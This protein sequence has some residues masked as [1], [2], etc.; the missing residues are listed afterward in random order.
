MIE[1]LVSQGALLG[2]FACLTVSGGIVL[3]IR[4]G[5]LRAR[6]R[7]A[8]NRNRE[9]GHILNNTSDGIVFLS[10]SG[11][12]IWANE[13][14]LAM[15]GFTLGEILGRNPL[16]YAIP[17][18]DR[19]PQQV[20]DS[21]RF[22]PLDPQWTELHVYRN[23]R[24][25]GSL[26][27]N[28]ISLSFH[29]PATGPDLTILVCRDISRQI[30]AQEELAAARADLD[31]AATR[32]SLTGLANR[33]L[34]MDFL[35]RL[36]RRIASGERVG[37][38]VVHIDVDRFKQINDT[39]GHAAGDAVLC[40]VADVLAARCDGSSLMSRPGGDE[41]VGVISGLA[42]IESLRDLAE[43]LRHDIGTGIG[44]Q[45][46][47]ISTSVSIG[48]AFLEPDDTEPD[49][50]LIRSD[51]A[52]YQAKRAGRGRSVV[53]DDDL[54]SRHDRAN[55]L[56]RHLRDEIE[57]GHLVFD[58]QPVIDV[59]S[60]AVSGVETLVRWEHPTEGRLMPD[61]FLPLAVENGLMAELD[62][63]AI[64]SLLDLGVMLAER[65]HPAVRL[66]FNASPQ[67]LADPGLLDRL[68]WAC[69]A[70]DIDPGRV[71]IEILETVVLS[72]GQAEN[73]NIRTI[74]SLHD[75][76]F[77]IILDDFGTGHAGLAHLADL[78]I[79]G[80]KLD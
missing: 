71:R 44:W 60:G 70:R 11:Q 72:D 46:R 55:R 61:R 66:A 8:E 19:P 64:V 21:F 43:G 58:F 69:A 16:T 28:Q 54:R 50:V 12:M 73:P 48:A 79:A 62:H 75:A 9:L 38:A 78:P 1:H 3:S 67:L 20:I 7:A 41:F 18:E 56:G 39:H 51:Y 32:D 15:H 26:F 68:L 63:S 5:Q 59:A 23:I 29:R 22:D 24:K 40:H 53:Y 80:I 36:T 52:L 30:E 2:A 65:G 14:Y 27:W 6:L 17:E 31:I 42:D 74:R 13:T 34:L 10:M 25:D 47:H 4:I 76:G 35:D 37:A 49:G 77:G 57:D 45:D 33:R